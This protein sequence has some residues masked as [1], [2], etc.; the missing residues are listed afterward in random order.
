MASIQLS[1]SAKKNK[2]L[3]VQEILIRFCH[4]RINQRAKSGILINADF[5]NQ[6]AQTILIPRTRVVSPARLEEMRRAETALRELSSLKT[7]IME[8]FAEASAKHKIIQDHWLINVIRQFKGVSV[9]EGHTFFSLWDKFSA[10]KRVSHQRQAM[11]KVLRSVLERYEQVRQM[12]NANFDLSLESLNNEMLLDFEKFLRLEHTYV[13]LYPHI[14]RH[15]DRKP[16]QRGQNT[17]TDRVSILRTFVLW[18]K[19]NGYT[20]NDPFVHYESKPEVY[21]TPIYIS[22]EEREILR[23]HPMPTASLAVVRDIF[24]F[25]CCIGCRVGDLLK[26]TKTNIVNGAIEYIPHKTKDGRPVVVRVPLNKTAL[27]ILERYQH[28]PTE[29][30][31]P[32]I[33]A[34]KYNEGIKKTFKVAGLDRM[35]TR[36]NTIT[37]EPEQKPLYEIASSHMARRTFIGNLYK[38]VQDP[39][40]IGALSGHVEGSTAFARYRAID[41]DM[42]KDTVSLLDV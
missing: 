14:Y 32:F 41:D 22:M 15:L 34:P 35:V 29:K 18:A 27:E 16:K 24:I 40:L 36:L 6:D 11:Y 30:L 10:S 12:Q 42:K 7:Y 13:N 31:L 9:E 37:G 17:I 21:G 25:Q 23:T 20:E 33:C 28:V 19:N 4:N 39:N 26:M 8:A 1:L 2:E 5:W 38:K 3:G